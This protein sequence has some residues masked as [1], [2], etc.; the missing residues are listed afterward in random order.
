[1]IKKLN[2]IIF[3]LVLLILLIYVKGTYSDDVFTDTIVVSARKW[4]EPLTHINHGGTCRSWNIETDNWTH[5]HPTVVNEGPMVSADFNADGYPDVVMSFNDGIW[6]HTVNPIGEPP[7]D[8]YDYWGWMDPTPAYSLAAGD[9]DGDGY[10]DLIGT[11]FNGIWFYSF[12]TDTWTR[13]T[14]YVTTGSI[15]AADFNGDGYCDVASVWPGDG[16]WVQDGLTLKWSR[17]DGDGAYRLASADIT[18]DGR[19]E[20]IASYKYYG[21]WYW[22]FVNEAWTQMTENFNRGAPISAGNYNGDDYADV[23]SIWSGYLWWQDGHTLE[24]HQMS[25]ITRIINLTTVK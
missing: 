24:W 2:F 12:F 18:G 1:M 3:A 17:I 13:M 11:W 15:T 25:Q 4:S 20:L 23:A 8:A 9:V 6:F 22:D 10:I 19:A 21:I 16:L 7:H 5:V 14:P